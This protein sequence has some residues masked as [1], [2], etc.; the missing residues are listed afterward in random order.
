MSHQA[1]RVLQL[2]AKDQKIKKPWIIVKSENSQVLASVG[3]YDG[4]LSNSG[5]K[6]TQV[7]RSKQLQDQGL[8]A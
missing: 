4:M 5:P 6:Y 7:V 3:L 1:A 8:S 2:S